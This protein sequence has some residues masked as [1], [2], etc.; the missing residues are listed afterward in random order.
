MIAL[1]Q[2]L[3]ARRDA[4][5]KLF[6]PYMTGGLNDDWTAHVQ[7]MA[8][9]GA[10]AIEIGIPFSDPVMDGPTIQ[11][12]SEMALLAG[13]TPDSILAELNGIDID[14]P[15]VVMTY[16]NIAYRIGHQRFAESLAAAGV[17]G[18][19]LPDLPL[20]ESGDWRAA[21]ERAGV[22]HVLLAAPTAPDSRLPLICQATRGF[23]YSVGLV[24]TTGERSALAATAVP[25]ARRLKAITDVPVIVGVGV[26]NGAQAAQVC[27][28]ADGAVIASALM[29]RVLDGA[30]PQDTEEFVRDIRSH[31]DV[32]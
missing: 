21:A 32:S 17:S 10:D 12:A 20:E 25:M 19:I 30:S 11:Q 1:E 5:R 15:L 28:E 29:R 6:V 14:V 13:A 9:G 24:G 23:V 31:I 18:T 8:A 22:Q 3:R 26:S 27:Q 4:G 16:Y 2:H 7:A